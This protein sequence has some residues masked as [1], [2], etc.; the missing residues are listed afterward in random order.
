[1]KAM[2]KM[3]MS[4]NRTKYLKSLYLTL[5]AVWWMRNSS[6]LLNKPRNVGGKLAG[7]RMSYSQKIEDAT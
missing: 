3:K 6:S 2:K 1:M 7:R 4:S 5:R